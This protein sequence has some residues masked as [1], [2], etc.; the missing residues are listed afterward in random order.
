MLVPLFSPL[1]VADDGG[2]MSPSDNR[3]DTDESPCSPG[4]DDGMTIEEMLVSPNDLNEKQSHKLVQ[5]FKCLIC[6]RNM[7]S[8]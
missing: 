8:V 2:R 1:S 3:M 7:V 6:N 4:S 5:A